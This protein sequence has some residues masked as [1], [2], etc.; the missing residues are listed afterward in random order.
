M[1]KILTIF[2]VTVILL[3]LQIPVAALELSAKSAIVMAKSGEIVFERDADTRRPMASTTKIMTALVAIES[4][5]LQR[6]VT[7]APEA[8]GVEGS[9]V[10][11]KAG[12]RL[13]LESLVW[14]LMLESAN[15]AA[16][17]IAMELGGSIEGF[18]ALM[19]E[20]AASLGL[21]NT[22][23]TNPHGLSDEDHYTTARELALLSA[24]AL[25]NETFRTIAASPSHRIRIGDTERMLHNHNKMLRLYDGA[26]GV[27][28]GFTKASGRCLVSAAEREG[29]TLVAV[30]LNAPDDWHDH[31]AML[32]LGFSSLESVR[33]I[34]AGES[35]CIIPCIG[36]DFPDITV[37]NRDALSVVLPKGTHEIKRTIEVPRYFWAPIEAG[38]IVGRIVFREGERILGEVPLYAETSAARVQYKKNIF[39]KIFD[40]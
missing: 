40:H 4:G 37:K 2:L 29:L 23:F 27:K 9:S 10:Y 11:L 22:H 8:V 7:V 34:E 12:D 1:R 18:A 16:A 33:L 32:D 39:D 25:Q 3:G 6:E 14:A 17:A 30:T 31:A 38:E 20:K 21:E 24:H 36:G 15:D 13:N 19:N 5:D 26:V 35:A 28:T